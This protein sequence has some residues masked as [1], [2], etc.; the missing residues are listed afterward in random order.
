MIKTENKRS[1][2]LEPEDYSYIL[3]HLGFRSKVIIL[4]IEKKWRKLQFV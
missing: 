1:N 2:M 3:L 4:T